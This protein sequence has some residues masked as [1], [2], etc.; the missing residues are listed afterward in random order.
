MWIVLGLTWVAMGF[1][2]LFEPEMPRPGLL[3]TLLGPAARSVLWIVAGL[4]AASLA[5]FSGRGMPSW[6]D[7]AAVFSLTIPPAIRLTSYGI[8]GALAIVPPNPPGDWSALSDFFL[9][10]GLVLALWGVARWPDDNT[11]GPEDDQRVG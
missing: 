2:V 3:H 6:A 11:E 1:H 4:L 9:W 5:A 7:R 10:L 8:Y